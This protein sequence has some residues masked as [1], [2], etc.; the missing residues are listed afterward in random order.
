MLTRQVKFFTLGNKFLRLVDFS[1]LSCKA[2]DSAHT[3]RILNQ[4][5]KLHGQGCRAPPAGALLRLASSRH[6]P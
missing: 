2:I 4:R 3:V 5:D 1:F 6:Q